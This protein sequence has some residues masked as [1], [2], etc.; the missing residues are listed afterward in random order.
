MVTSWLGFKEVKVLGC[1]ISWG[2][3]KLGEDRK[4]SIESKAFP[5]N[6]KSMQL[7]LGSA[8]FFKG[9]VVNLF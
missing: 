2:R 5:T 1:E 8:L 7:F 3:Y 9:F 4:K 6:K